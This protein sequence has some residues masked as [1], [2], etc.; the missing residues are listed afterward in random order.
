MVIKTTM[1][2]KSSTE[3]NASNRPFERALSSTETGFRSKYV[4][5]TV[6]Q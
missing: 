6:C 4:R 3:F 5:H 1:A 2:A